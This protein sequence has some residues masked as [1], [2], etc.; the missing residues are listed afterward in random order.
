MPSGIWTASPRP[1]GAL[2]RQPGIALLRRKCNIRITR[3]YQGPPG[4]LS[5]LLNGDR[6]LHLRQTM[7][8]HTSSDQITPSHDTRED[9]VLLWRVALNEEFKS[10]SMLLALGKVA[11]ITLLLM[12]AFQLAKTLFYPDITIIETHITTIAFTTLLAVFAASFVFRNQQKIL[13]AMTAEVHERRRAEEALRNRTDELARVHRQL[14]ASHRE[15]NLYLDI[16]THDIGNTENVSNLY[17]E[18]LVE[19]LDGES[20]GYAE[21]LKR[22]VQKSIEILGIV[23]K[24]R[25]IYAGPP[26]IRPTDLDAVIR[27]ETANFP[28]ASIRYEG[29]SR[30]VLADDLLCEI[31]GNLIGNAVKYGGSGVAITVRVEEQDGEVLVSVEDTGP[32]IPDADK[33]VIFHRYEQQK[34][35]V[36]EGLGLYL[37]RILVERYGGR[38]R[39]EDR[40]PGRHEEGA[41][42]LFTLREAAGG[43]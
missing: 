6:G 10:A 31:F 28:E 43:E 33:Q 17:A 32:G 1:A 8:T 42:F 4:R 12:S 14:E 29:T 2:Y 24:I 5:H 22:S 9:A 38:I 21:K 23:S 35:G 16:L 20:A 19:T 26:D 37:V 25:R 13:R 27:A 36:G 30:Q 34:R 15:A 41:V 3:R 40:V 39:V 18:L 7:S 11:A